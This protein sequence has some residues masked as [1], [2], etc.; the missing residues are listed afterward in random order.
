VD[1]DRAIVATIA[2]AALFDLRG[3]I[4]VGAVVTGGN[5]TLASRRT[6]DPPSSPSRFFGNVEDSMQSGV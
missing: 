5:P 6:I 3:F 2:T 4:T 1:V